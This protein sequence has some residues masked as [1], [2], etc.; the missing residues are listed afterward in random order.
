MMPPGTSTLLRVHGPY[1]SEVEI[2]EGMRISEETG[3]AD[4]QYRDDSRPRPRQ[5]GA[6]DEEDLGEEFLQRY[7]EAVTMAMD[8]EMISTS[9]IQR[10]FRIG[11]NTAARHNGEARN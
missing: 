8:M 7:D 5:S 2:K 3:Q 9:Y 11:Y 10:R 6:K 1:L 4:I